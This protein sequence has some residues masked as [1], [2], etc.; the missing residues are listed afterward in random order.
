MTG[1]DAILVTKPSAIH[2]RPWE[3]GAEHI[4]ALDRT[5][6]EM[7]KFK[8][9]DSDYKDIV[10][11][12]IKGL[13]RRAFT[14]RDRLQSS[15]STFLVPYSQNPDFVARSDILNNIKEQFGLGQHKGPVQSRGRVSLYG[16]GGVGN[17]QPDIAIFWVYA[18][19]ADRF[20]ESYTSIAK[21][22]NIPGH[23]EIK[24]DI[25][26]EQA[27]QANSELA[28]YIPECN[29]GTILITTRNKQVGIK[30]CQGKPPVEVINMTD[31]EAY[32]LMQ[33]I[34]NDWQISADKADFAFVGQLSEPF[35]MVGRDSET[36][37]AVTATWI[38]SFEQIKRQ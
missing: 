32:N 16:L 29:Y 14:V 21:K 36:P 7:V 34:L 15:K 24:A 33:S 25:L 19:N 23:D 31:T 5:H 6:S 22:Y 4:C 27:A 9:N 1:P 38:I 20:R 2:C 11:E 13:S 26:S 30:L 37:H 3:D 35:E 10:K 8:P 17:T 12:K 28:C 18:S